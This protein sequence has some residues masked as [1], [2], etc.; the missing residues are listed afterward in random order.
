MHDCEILVIV[1]RYDDPEQLPVHRSSTPRAPV[2]PSLT[3]SNRTE[4]P[5][6]SYSSLYRFVITVG[7]AGLLVTVA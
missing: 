7:H 4:D 3:V 1:F 6:P 5:G 2:Q